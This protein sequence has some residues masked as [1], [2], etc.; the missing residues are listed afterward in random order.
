[1]KKNRM[2]MSLLLFL[3]L[4]SSLF[5]IEKNKKKFTLELYTGFSTLN[6]SDLNLRAEN[7]EQRERFFRDDYYSYLETM[8]KINSLEKQMQEGFETIKNAFPLG[9]RLK[10]Y[11]NNSMAIS[12]GFLYLSRNQTSDVLQEFYFNYDSRQYKVTQEYSPYTLT[13][14][15]YAPM[16]GIHLGKK[17]SRTLEIEGCVSGG[18]I[19]AS[20]GYTFEQQ[21]RWYFADSTPLHRTP[22]W[23]VEE[24][25]SGTGINL[26]SSVRLNID[27]GNNI[28]IFLESGYAYR[29]VN[30]LSGSGLEKIGT[31]YS[32]WEGEWGIKESHLVTE[33]GSFDSQYPSNYWGENALPKMREFKLNLSGFQ[34]RVGISFTFFKT[35]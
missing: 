21:E 19:F 24:N 13:V 8:G 32:S 26:D 23:F 11:L 25:G 12:L 9:F 10:Y 16:I 28:G 35:N 6:P 18:P 14:Q 5:P 7:E 27:M 4:V 30:Q 34:V 22:A 33:W 15:G 2:I 20:C 17:I 3:V 1:M 29:R 31:D